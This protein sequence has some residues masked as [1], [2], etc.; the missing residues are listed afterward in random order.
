MRH[1]EWNTDPLS[2]TEYG[3][4]EARSVKGSFDKP[5]TQVS[6]VWKAVFDL[7]QRS[8]TFDIYQRYSKSAFK[9]RFDLYKDTFDSPV[10]FIKC[11]V[12]LT[13]DKDVSKATSTPLI[14]F[15]P[16]VAQLC[17]TLDGDQ[18]WSKANFLSR[19][20]Y[21]TTRNCDEDDRLNSSLKMT[22]GQQ[23]RE[24]ITAYFTCV[25]CN[26]KA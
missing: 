9:Y 25:A 21:I 24:F 4:L 12:V 23:P 22:K 1:R 14:T 10:T 17:Y 13:W 16:C 20:L 8:H 26:L 3:E 7:G 11:V 2:E 18:R 19:R 5:L 6:N 15:D